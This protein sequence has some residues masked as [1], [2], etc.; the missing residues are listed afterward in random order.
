MSEELIKRQLLK[1]GKQALDFEYYEIGE[2]TLNQLKKAKIIPNKNY[3]KYGS[4]K[5]DCLLVN[6][7]NKKT[8]QVIVSLEYKKPSDFKTASQKLSAIRQC[9]TVAQEINAKIGVITDGQIYFWINP[10]QKLKDNKYSDEVTGKERSYTHIRNEDKKDLTERFIIHDNKNK[11]YSKLDDDTKNT[12]DYINRIIQ[13]ISETNSTLKPIQEVD[14]LPLAKSVWQD[15]YINTGKDPT[16]CL[17][18]VVELFIFKFLSDLNVLKN[19]HSFQYL[20]DLTNRSQDKDILKYY[21]RNSRLKISELFPK[22]EK[23]NTTIINGT[24]FVD[25][26]G[27]PVTSQAHL[28]VNSIKK[29]NQ[30]G[31]LKHIKKEFKTKLFEIFLKQSKDKSRLGQFFT[32]RKVVKAI[33]EM[34]DVEKLKNGAN[35]CDPFCGVGGFICEAL[36]NT[37]RKN[38]FMPKNGKIKTMINY[39]GFDKGSDDE[40][41]RTIILAKANMVI[42]LSEIV[43]RN[44]TLTKEFAKTF[45]QIFT[46]L[47]DSN[48]GTLKITNKEEDKY[49]LILTNPP[50]ISG[51]VKSIKDEINAEGL[52]NEYTENGKGV[53]G[54]ALEW[55]VKNLK[56]EG[57][58]FIIVPHSIFNVSQNQKLRQYILKQCYLEGI[59]SLP[60]KTFFN[61]PQ[62]T[63][64]LIITKKQ[65][66]SETQTNPVFT[67]IV[68]NIGETLDVNRFEIEGKS[69]LEKAKDLFNAFKG[70][71]KSF[72][73]NEIGDNRCKL[74]EISYF[75]KNKNWIIENLWNKEEKIELGIQEEVE[76]IDLDEF[77][78]RLQ[79]AQKE[80]S[81]QI[82]NVAKIKS[83]KKIN[84][85]QEK[86]GTLFE[87]PK[88]NSGIT[89]EFCNSNKGD[90]PVFA[91]S[92]NKDSVLGHIKDNIKG[93]HYYSDCLSWNRNGSVG[94]VFIRKG[95]FTTNEDHRAMVIKP[96]YTDFL[97]KN[98]LKVEIEKRLLEEGFS[99]LDKCGVEKIKEV[100]INI[101]TNKENFDLSMQQEIYKK[102][103]II[104][105]AKTELTQLREQLY[106]SEFKFSDRIEVVE[107]PLIEI[108]EPKKGNAKYTKDYIRKNIGDYPV[109]SS[110]TTNEGIIGRINSFDYNTKCLTWTTDGVY[111]G[112]VFLRNGKFSMTTHCGAL[113]PR[114]EWKDKIDLNYMYF[115]LNKKLREEAIGDINKRVTIGNIETI[116]IEIPKGK[117]GLDLG[118][119]TTLSQK[120]SE[121]NRIKSN[122]VNQLDSLNDSFVSVI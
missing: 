86:I 13:N 10:S 116:T 17:Y 3:E 53:E 46:L 36:H 28:F 38:D 97:D 77:Q 111:A 90:I 20:I 51:G 121:L 41:K 81:K 34:S 64:I 100:T 62:K 63:Y 78:N 8:P 70:S 101:P 42:Y 23:D 5:P 31:S 66:E 122:F 60:S 48:L 26:N 89:K 87:F 58:A 91:S 52:E 24:I 106:N 49:D 115:E 45:N 2:T 59:I 54:L 99:F 55:I 103:K 102:S 37:K 29:Y 74:A 4:K 105:M 93:I 82:E 120:Y 56:K 16:K 110:Q 47:T 44:P 117:N 98:Y 104:Q 19:E 94:Y 88:T 92:K 109:Y 40:E 1:N 68:S 80:I 85:K 9:N 11:E 25:S 57:K 83:K 6:K 22:S 33:V 18:N 67:Y 108:F 95:K 84:L 114:E 35:F 76:E 61:T 12:I 69:D 21:A 73:V 96:E 50:Y 65:K 72:P 118:Q 14:P 43:E 27:Q 107:L 7:Q 112:T 119:Q 79:E 71:P 32:P 113:I 15:I 39:T 75:E 30:F